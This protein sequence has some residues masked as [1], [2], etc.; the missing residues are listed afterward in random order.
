MAPST[1]AAS[2]ELE[3]LCSLFTSAKLFDGLESLGVQCLS[4]FIG[5]VEIS[6]YEVRQNCPS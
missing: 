3:Q 4:D 2:R 6:K 1:A 5:L